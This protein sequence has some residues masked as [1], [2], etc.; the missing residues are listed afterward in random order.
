MCFLQ[1]LE[2]QW[3]RRVG[4]PAVIRVRA[5]VGKFD[6]RITPMS[7]EKSQRRR[8]EAAWWSLRPKQAGRFGI[9]R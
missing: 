6:S 8:S 1:L 5:H 7:P 2:G 3:A 9:F 4:R